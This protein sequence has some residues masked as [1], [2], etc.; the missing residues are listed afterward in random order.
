MECISYDVKGHGKILLS[1]T[2]DQMVRVQ[3][4]HSNGQ[5][6][7]LVPL[8]NPK[9]YHEKE[10]DFVKKNDHR[11]T[12]EILNLIEEKGNGGEEEEGGKGEEYGV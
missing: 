12:T 7:D 11:T 3:L 1:T 8:P 10:L 6:E 2:D 9:T 4:L 5:P